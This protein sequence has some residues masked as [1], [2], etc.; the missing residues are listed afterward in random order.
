VVVLGTMLELGPDSA[1]LHAAMAD[2]VLAAEPQLVAAVGEFAV[3]F[4]CHRA[5]LGKR[6]LLSEDPDAL[7]RAL[8][9]RLR[10]NELVLVKGS[11]GVR[12]ERVVTHL[13]EDEEAHCSTTS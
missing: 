2:A 9:R 10:G 8:A 1:A 6:L 4:E 7:G 5:R 12:M 3:A 13:L 11:R